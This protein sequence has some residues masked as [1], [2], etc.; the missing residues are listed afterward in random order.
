VGGRS[1]AARRRAG[2]LGDG[3]LPYLVSPRSLAAGID[4]VRSH[5]RDAGRD[6]D[7]LR[8][9]VVAFALVDEDGESARRSAREHL[10]QRYGMEFQP[11]HVERLCVVGTPEECADRLRQYADAGAAFVSLNPAVDD[12]GF[13]TQVE[14]LHEIARPVLGAAT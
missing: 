3:W 6:P 8:H 2:R 14:R 5:A 12:G 7:E 1:Q 10:S 9:G 11:H 4:E 13:L